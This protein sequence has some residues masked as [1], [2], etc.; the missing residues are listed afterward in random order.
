MI[1]SQHDDLIRCDTPGFVVG[2]A[3]PYSMQDLHTVS[4]DVHF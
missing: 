3:A 1:V 4:D 2:R